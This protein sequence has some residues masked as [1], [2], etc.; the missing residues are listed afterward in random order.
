VSRVT[1]NVKRIESA[2]F[3]GCLSLRVVQFQLP[4]Q[5]WRVFTDAFNDCSLLEPISLPSSVEFIVS[6]GFCQSDDRF[7]FIV[8]GH[9]FMMQHD[10][11]IR[12]SGR[13]L[14]R[15]LGFSE[16]F[17]ISRDITVLGAE[18]FSHNSSLRTLDFESAFCIT[19]VLDH[20]F[21]CC[22]TLRF[23]ELPK[24][25]RF[26]G[27]ECFSFCIE[28]EE[29]VF[30]SPAIVQRIESLAF[31]RCGSLTSFTVPS[32]VST[33]GYGVFEGCEALTSVT[34]ETP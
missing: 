7:P 9:N 19:H 22:Y 21:I 26:I 17:C 4:S 20:S 8:N 31:S 16:T 25:V 6:G 33:L 5:C 1:S 28:L 30:E 18:S 12:A 32:S 13:E 24:S 10:C 3:E 2:V 29:V 11:L 27:S 14:I 15:Y 34:F 23:I